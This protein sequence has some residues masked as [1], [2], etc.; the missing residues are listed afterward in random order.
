MSSKANTSDDAELTPDFEPAATEEAK[1]EPEVIVVNEPVDISGKP[2][3]YED[4]GIENKSETIVDA[5]IAK[6]KTDLEA[7]AAAAVVEPK[8]IPKHYIITDTN[9]G[10]LFR[11][12]LVNEF[13]KELFRREHIYASGMLYPEL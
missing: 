5:A 11:T 1:P 9:E 8:P 3:F 4:G 10:K 12:I 7:E 6:S 13:T 2:S